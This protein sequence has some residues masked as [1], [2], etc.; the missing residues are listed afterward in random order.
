MTDVE[1][2]CIPGALI[3]PDPPATWDPGTASRS[4]VWP[5]LC[6]RG[7]PREVPFSTARPDRQALLPVRTAVT[8]RTGHRCAHGCASRRCC[9]SRRFPRGRATAGKFSPVAAPGKASDGDP[10]SPMTRTRSLS[11]IGRRRRAS[12]PPHQRHQPGD[13]ACVCQKSNEQHRGGGPSRRQAGQAAWEGPTRTR[14]GGAHC[15]PVP[16][17]TAPCARVRPA[18]HVMSAWAGVCAPYARVH[19][20][21]CP[22]LRVYSRTHTPVH[23]CTCR[24]TPSLRAQGERGVQACG[25]LR[26]RR[27]H[28]AGP[29]AASAPGS[30]PASPASPG[31]PTSR[32]SPATAAGAGARHTRHRRTGRP[33][34]P[35]PT[36]AA[37]SAPPARQRVWVP[38][39]EG[40][41][42]ASVTGQGRRYWG[43]RGRTAGAGGAGV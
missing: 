42:L 32:G 39:R 8:K 35:A 33:A 43:V 11:P 30:A 10:N 5:A 40:R 24:T 23:A 6:P 37:A 31:S 3:P 17:G 26:R 20:A 12:T 18:T 4:R 22:C 28:L 15:G 21:T 19:T 36:A 38:R 16:V 1:V 2:A 34:G 25:A 41:A 9:L 7:P 29:R 27:T 14:R 13:F